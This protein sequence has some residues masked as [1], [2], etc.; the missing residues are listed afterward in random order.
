MEDRRREDLLDR[1]EHLEKSYV[2]F[3]FNLKSS[4]LE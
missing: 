1:N 4:I 3:I 2:N